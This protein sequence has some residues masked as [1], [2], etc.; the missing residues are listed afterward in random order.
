MDTYIAAIKAQRLTRQRDDSTTQKYRIA[1]MGCGDAKLA[2]T[3][4]DGSGI[5][6]VFSFD[7][8]TNDNPYITRACSM[9]DTSLPSNSI[10]LVIFCLSLMGTDWLSFVKEGVRIARKP[11]RSTTKTTTTGAEIWI[12]EVKSRF[13]PEKTNKGALALP[14][15]IDACTSCGLQLLS[16]VTTIPFVKKQKQ[17]QETRKVPLLI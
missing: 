7:L 13:A 1:D 3:L 16:L 2:R 11:A 8:A 17:K 10:D 6:E 15:F 9:S 5:E 4:D 12:A 14:S